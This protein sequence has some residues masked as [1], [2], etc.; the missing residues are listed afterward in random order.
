MATTVIG[1]FN[2]DKAVQ[3]VMAELHDAGFESGSVAVLEG[4]KDE[5]IAAIT[6]HGFSQD[7]AGEYAAAAGRGK[8]LLAV[9]TSEQEVERAVAVL[10]RHEAPGQEGREEQQQGS[11]GGAQAVREVEEELSI[12][13]RQVGRGGVRVT[14]HV[15]EQP[16]EETVTLREEKV[17]AKRQ[18]ADRVLSSE[19]ADEAFA[20]KSVELTATGEEVEVRKE[21]RV[22]GEVVLG[23][24]ATERE[25]TVKDTVRRSEVEVEE[26]AAKKGRKAG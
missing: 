2:D 5:L 18:A 15:S 24:T 3:K 8:K 26:I 19:E 4:G 21:A 16:V 7:D 11:R 13:K 6:G 14:T 17:A 1:T 22:T 10:E 9:H 12:A 23:K 25:Q 20:E